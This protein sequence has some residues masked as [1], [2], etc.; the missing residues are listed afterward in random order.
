MIDI[1]HPH[2][3]TEAER[4]AF[5]KAWK[6]CMPKPGTKF[7]NSIPIIYGTGGEAPVMS[8]GVWDQLMDEVEEE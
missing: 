3:M 1:E 8:K 5:I 6:E 2:L 7:E 4:K